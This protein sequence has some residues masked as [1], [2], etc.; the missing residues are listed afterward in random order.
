MREIEEKYINY[1]DEKIAEHNS[2]S[3]QHKID[4]RKDESDL[5][6]IKVNIYE[7]FRTLFLSDIKQLEGKNIGEKA[8]INI[9][10]GFLLRFDTIPTNWK[11]SLDKA[12]EHGDTTKQ[13]IEEHK[14]S[15]AKG[16]KDRFIE[17]FEEHGRH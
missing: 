15:V 5:E 4:D 17:M 8:D 1:I 12:I 14:M 13:V 3:E 9:Y 7:I 2:I 10:G 16:L 11:M 6:K